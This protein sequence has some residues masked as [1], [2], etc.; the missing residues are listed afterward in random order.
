M[1]LM[2][3]LWPNMAETTNKKFC[4]DVKDQLGDEHIWKPLFQTGHVVVSQHRLFFNE[5][6][7]QIPRMTQMTWTELN[8]T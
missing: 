6:Q 8:W 7:W 2:K 1:F 4:W 3:K 5:N